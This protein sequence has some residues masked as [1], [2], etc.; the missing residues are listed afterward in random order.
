MPSDIY[1]EKEADYGSTSCINHS[2]QNKHISTQQA[3]VLG[4]LL[5][6]FFSSMMVT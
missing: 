2:K 4:V 1:P 5:F 6:S 3:E